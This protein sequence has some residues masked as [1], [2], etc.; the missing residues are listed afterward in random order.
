MPKTALVV[1]TARSLEW[2]LNEH[3]SGN[4]RLDPV[5]ARNCEFLVC[6]QNCRNASFGAPTVA[7]RAAFLIGHISG[8]VP[9]REPDR[10]VVKICDYVAVNL[11]NIWAKSGHL[12]YPV[13]YTTLDELGIDLSSLS[14]FM[15]LTVSGGGFSEGPAAPTAAPPGPTRGHAPAGDPDAWRRFDAILAQLDRV[16]D[17]PNPSNPLEWDEYGLPR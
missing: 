11:Q 6:T 16:P 2:I 10:W 17:V 9:A 14:P 12:R 8:V 1:F 5:R 15:P 4:W 7:H 3:G 13:R